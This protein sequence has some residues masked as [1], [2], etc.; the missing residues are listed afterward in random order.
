[1]QVNPETAP[2]NKFS[3]NVISV[4]YLRFKKR[5]LHVSNA[6]KNTFI[7][8]NNYLHIGERLSILLPPDL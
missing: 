7:V 5:Y 2:A 6:V 8:I 1:M 3:P 4:A